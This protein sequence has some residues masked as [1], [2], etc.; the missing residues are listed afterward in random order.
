MQPKEHTARKRRVPCGMAAGKTLPRAKKE[1]FFCTKN[2]SL[3][4][5]HRE[6]RVSRKALLLC[7]G[8]Q[9][10]FLP[11]SLFQ[12][13]LGCFSKKILLISTSPLLPGQALPFVK[14]RKEAKAFQGES[15]DPLPL[16]PFSTTQRLRLWK[17]ETIRR[18]PRGIAPKV[19]LG[20]RD[21]T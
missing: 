10:C 7:R 13:R 4:L 2:G 6:T 9:V 21:C 20:W 8:G 3:L 5:L 19:A 18:K 12:L 14:R 16:D 11:Y 1:P 15:F 17:P